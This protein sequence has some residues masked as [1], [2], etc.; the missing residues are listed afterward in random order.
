DV[1]LKPNLGW[2]LHLPGAVSAPWVVEAVIE[3][4][5]PHVGAIFLVESNQILVDVERALRQTGLDRVCRA[6]GVTWV[7]MSR[8][9]FRR[10]KTGHAVLPHIEVP[11]ILTRAALV[12]LPVMKTHGRT[13][14]TGAVTD[15]G[16]GRRELRHNSHLVV[17]EAPAV[18][19]EAVR[20]RFAV[21]DGT[22]GLEGNGPKSGR[23]R[24][25]DLVLASADAVALDTVA[26]KVMG[27]DP[28]GVAHL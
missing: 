9:A 19:N 2:D 21:M 11:E 20:P 3:V 13:T 10:V 7:N 26:A 1:A 12:T 18:V 28:A 25:A 8:G 17:N 4:L 23:P 15:Q 6:H 16:G 14:L 27:I 24:V 22:V 5:R